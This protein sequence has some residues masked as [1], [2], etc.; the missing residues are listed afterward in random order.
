[1][2]DIF[3]TTGG[4]AQLKDRFGSLAARRLVYVPKP[5]PVRFQR[6]SVPLPERFGDHS[7]RRPGEDRG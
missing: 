3:N 5:I 1:M 6:S 4:F 2:S 7:T